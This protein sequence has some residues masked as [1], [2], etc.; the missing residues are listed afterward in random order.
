MVGGRYAV[1]VT[2][3]TNLSK[4]VVI[5]SQQ[6]KSGPREGIEGVIEGWVK[7][8][9][10]VVTGN[11]NLGDHAEVGEQFRH[12][13]EVI[14]VPRSAWTVCGISPLRVMASSMN[15]CASSAVSWWDTIQDGV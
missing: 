11:E 3:L 8:A 7:E 13:P 12:Q 5:V 2:A 4:V 9:A 1:T 10:G 6:D 15:S 14:D